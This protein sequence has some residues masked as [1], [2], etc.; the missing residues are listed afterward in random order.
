[1]KLA[2]IERMPTDMISVDTETY[3]IIVGLPAPDLVCMSYGWLGWRITEDG[4]MIDAVVGK[5]IN[6]AD[7]IDLFQ[8]LFMSEGP[9]PIIV[10]ANFKFDMLVMAVRLARLGIDAMPAI[11]RALM[12]TQTI[13]D[14]QIAEALDA[15]AEGC[16]G[17]DPRTGGELINPETGRRGRYSLAMVVD[18]VLGR[19]D[20]KANDEWRKAYGELHPFPIEQWP[21]TAQQYPVDDV[22]NAGEVAL[23]QAGHWPRVGPHRW[24]ETMTCEW[25]GRTP[26]ETLGEG[27]VA[28]PC[29]AQ[30]RSRNLHDLANQVGSDFALGAGAAWGFLVDQ[31][32]VDLIEAD[33]L[34]GREDAL[35]PFLEAGLLRR[36]AGE[37]SRDMAAIARRVALA[38]GASTES[39]CSTCKGT[40]KV[41]SSKNPKSKINCTACAASG[42]DL[43]VAP[44]IPRTDTGRIGTGR[45]VLN[46]SADETL[47][48][49]ADHQE[50]AKTLEVYIPYLRRA[51]T[52][53]AGHNE[54]CPCVADETDGCTCPGPYRPIPL[55]LWPNVLLETGRTSYGGT[56]Q[57]FP[58]AP[59]RRNKDGK[60]IPSLRETVIARPGRLLCSCDY[61]AGELY[62]HAQSCRWILGYSG[63]GDA[64]L[65]NID[66]HSALAATVL[67]MTYPEF[68][69]HK[70]DPRCKNARQASKPFTFGK[71]GGMGSAKLVLQ[72]RKQGPDTPHPSGP[73]WIVV[74]DGTGKT[75]KVRGYKGLRFC[76]LMGR[77]EVCGETKRDTWRE[78]PISPTC[79]ACLECAEELGRT[80]LEQWRE[81]SPYF[82]FINDCVEYGQLI[83]EE[84]LDRWP[85]LQGW[86]TPG[87]LGQA[88]IMQ[89]YS[90]R[91]RGGIDYCSAAN[92]FFQGL[93]SDI[94]KLALRRSSRECYDVT[95]RTETGEPSPLFGSRI[96]C[97]QHDE[98]LAELPEDVAHEA[99]HRLSHIMV[100]AMQEVCPDLAATVE[101]P[102][103]LMRRWLKS[104]EPVYVDGRLVPWELPA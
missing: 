78:R 68:I 98:I 69:A 52:P 54:A 37:V 8:R 61:K 79:L 39:P 45:D 1:M 101:A 15:V 100:R 10:G 41:P 92:G 29:F 53:V 21:P 13:Y 71:P 30:R 80:W 25:C 40:G 7:A 19:Q 43:A 88:E 3:P 55:T 90:G 64:L 57:Q 97:F 51:R 82:A 81:N 103:A 85:H 50:G 38:Y 17:K 56:I 22:V 33:A 35:V 62:T 66:P 18:L 76:I 48:L 104:A 42:F 14:V 70:K 44:N 6:E 75:K 20:A 24:G 87:R 59:G 72:Q 5:L 83:T 23:A 32:S 26:A 34:D 77:A 89:H 67:G 73:T 60:W 28:I 84:A 31:E 93:L 74:D 4:N 12:D 58:R 102:P 46:E 11:W 63:L 36:K 9:A 47:M 16:L 65:Q 86:F 27:G 95:A 94:G 91:V 49:L 99:G 2:D 96:I